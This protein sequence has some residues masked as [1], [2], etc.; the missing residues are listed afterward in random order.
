[1]GHGCN[2]HV[3]RTHTLSRPY[4]GP[5]SMVVPDIVLKFYK[6]MNWYSRPTAE[7][8]TPSDMAQGVRLFGTPY[9]AGRLYSHLNVN[10]NVPVETWIMTD[11]PHVAVGVSFGQDALIKVRETHG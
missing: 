9:A 4:I 8:P 7:F 3:H 1:M 10:T 6:L 5:M 2:E 11:L